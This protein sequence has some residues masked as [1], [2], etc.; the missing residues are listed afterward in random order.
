MGI[1]W[2][3]QY[4]L[5][6]AVLY[7]ENNFSSIPVKAINIWN[8]SGIPKCGLPFLAP[9]HWEKFAKIPFFYNKKKLFKCLITPSTL[10]IYKECRPHFEELRRHTFFLWYTLVILSNIG[11]QKRF[12]SSIQEQEFDRPRLFRME[13]I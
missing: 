7:R 6:L 5:S 3:L 11:N 1:K 10:K 9:H 4:R 8:Y 2:Q 12:S 13:P